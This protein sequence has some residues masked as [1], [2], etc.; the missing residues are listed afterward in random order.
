MADA[1]REGPGEPPPREVGGLEG[2][3]EDIPNAGPFPGSSERDFGD[4]AGYGTGGSTLDYREVVGEDP[5]AD[6][7]PNPLDA[8]MSTPTKGADPRA[9]RQEGPDR[10][11]SRS[12]QGA[13]PT[14][15]TGTRWLPPEGL[16]RMGP[17]V[18]LTLVAVS[19]G[20]MAWN[21]R[22]DRSQRTQQRTDR[23]T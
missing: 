7:R 16:R 22:A 21:R 20:F 3:G 15:A 23:S 10:R 9:G 1:R 12:T 17:I 5:V 11:G 2:I 8:V 6:R 13:P 19:L 4:S 14:G 18:G